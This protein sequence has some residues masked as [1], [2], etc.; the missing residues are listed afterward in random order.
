LPAGSPLIDAGLPVPN[1]SDRPGIDFQGSAP[2]I[3]F[4]RR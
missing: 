4:E 3:G 1:I 2:D